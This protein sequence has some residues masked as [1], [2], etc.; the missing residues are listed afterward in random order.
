M[1][2][3]RIRLLTGLVSGIGFMAGGVGFAD[4]DTV[5]VSTPEIQ[6]GKGSLGEIRQNTGA[7][8]DMGT[9]ALLA[10]NKVLSCGSMSSATPGGKIEG[11][12][13][14]TQLNASGPPTEAVPFK[15]VTDYKKNRG[16][17]KGT[18]AAAPGES[19]AIM[20]FAS[21]VDNNNNPQHYVRIMNDKAEFVTER[22]KI[23]DG[24]VN[25]G[26][27]Q[28]MYVGK[29]GNDFLFA[30]PDCNNG[31]TQDLFIIAVNTTTGAPKVSVRNKFTLF[32]SNIARGNCAVTGD[33]QISCV[34]AV[35]SNRPPEVGV[36]LAN[37]D[38]KAGKV[39]KR[40]IVAKSDPKNR[41]YANQP[42]IAALPNGKLA[43]M[44]TLS[45]GR[46]QDGNRRVNGAPE[47]AVLMTLDAKSFAV[48]D[49]TDPS[50]S[51]AAFAR[52]SHLFLSATNADGTAEIGALSGAPAASG[53]VTIR[54]ISIDAAGKIAMKPATLPVANNGDSQYWVRLGNNNP[55]NQGR[56]YLTPLTQI[57]NPGAGLATGWMPEVETF[58][59][60]PTSHFDPS[61]TANPKVRN[62]LYL[63]L[64]PAIAAANVNVNVTGVTPAAEIPPGPS[65]VTVNND[66]APSVPSPASGNTP[67][68]DSPAVG[69]STGGTSSGGLNG[70]QSSSA[71]ANAGGC[72]ASPRDATGGGLGAFALAGLG[73]ALVAARRRGR[74]S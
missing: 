40:A 58:T 32:D 14:V 64:V 67:L 37:I 57:K 11:A 25:H 45:K 71:D 29:D 22:L 56:G 47:Q 72:S 74:A 50:A 26:A 4:A 15:A 2:S 55:N 44:H 68:P 73:L 23:N 42:T 69:G 43:L 61:E 48:I 65:P 35:G 20:G 39:T 13:G 8:I 16:F 24:N 5:S 70:A 9:S 62:S 17:R 30:E 33:L 59:L 1:I 34:T 52:H 51:V 21:T 66:P 54:S 18:L 38:V 60:I 31:D 36:G 27:S 49:R 28:M 3:K 6:V 7:G 10:G 12:C 41:V 19:W 63:S 53:P 46:G